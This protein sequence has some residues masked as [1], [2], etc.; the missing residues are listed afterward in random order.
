MLQGA[1]V[2]LLKKIKRN[3][4]SVS[5]KK[6]STL[7]TF[8]NIVVLVMNIIQKCAIFNNDD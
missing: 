4:I 5:K 6:K 8:Q 1:S 3:Q 2:D 7:I